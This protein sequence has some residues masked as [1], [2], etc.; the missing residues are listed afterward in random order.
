[1]RRAWWALLSGWLAFCFASGV[2]AAKQVNPRPE[3]RGFWADGFNVGFKTPQQVDELLQRLHDAHCNAVFAQVRKG[4]DA[5]YQSHYEPWAK[6]N[7]QHWDALAYLITKAHAMSP[8]IQVHAWINTCAVGGNGSNPYNIVALH[9][10]WLSLNPQGNDFDGEATKI[11]PGHPDAAD[12]TFRVYLDVVRH[13]AVDGIHFDFVRYGGKEWGYNPV[14]VSRFEQQ[15]GN[16]AKVKRLADA[17]LPD[18]TDPLYKQWRR[19]QVT[20]LVRKVYVHAVQINPKIVVSAA[21]I[22]WAD[23]PKSDQDWND[24]SAAMNRVYQDWRSWLQEGMIDLA[25][26][27]TYFQAA[28]DDWHKHWAAW[29]KAHQYGRVASVAVG[30]WFNTIPQTLAQ[31][32][33]ARE[34]DIRGH[35]PYGVMLYSYAGTNLSD[36]PDIVTGKRK[37]LELQPAFYAALGQPSAYAS[38]PPFLS[39]VSGPPMPWKVAPKKGHCKGFVFTPDL[40]PVDGATVTLRGRGKTQ[41][42][43]AD[44]TGFYAFTDLKPGRYKIYVVAPGYT[45][46]IKTLD[47]NAGGVTTTQTMLGSPAVSRIPDITLMLAKSA[48]SAHPEGTPVQIDNLLIVLGSDTFPGNLIVRDAEGSSVRVRLQRPPVVPFQAGDV[49]TIAGTLQ[50]VEGELTVDGA[51]ARLTD[52]TAMPQ[53]P[54]VTASGLVT[55]Q[56]A[57]GFTLAG[58][59]GNTVRV[60]VAGRKDCGV[61]AS[62]FTFS[63]PSVGK[64]VRV[65][66][67]PAI[68]VSPDGKTRTRLLRPLDSFALTLLPD[69]SRLPAVGA[70]AVTCFR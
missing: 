43:R 63:L 6:D 47:V 15:V 1:M 23:G 19:D 56:D 55:A 30:C 39:D 66:G 60:T 8:P 14:S 44:G 37:E 33:T 52:M 59:D 50:Q 24:K 2:D 22:T 69:I 42:R 31:M 65:T 49:V 38:T 17:G 26:P 29:I 11:D 32:Q 46:Q 28:H 64:R 5:Y 16:R 68:T 35:L 12:W 62:I 36:M 13:Y 54:M 25:C 70:L 67:L 51:V 27:M 57:A 18:P 61:E 7:P 45:S 48:Q 4:G 41:T 10:D 9:H 53:F 3:L 58:D 21:V 40:T 34:P 20:N